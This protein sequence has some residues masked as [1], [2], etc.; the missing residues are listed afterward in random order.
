MRMID[1]LDSYY[2]SFQEQ[3]Q[4]PYTAFRSNFYDIEMEERGSQVGPRPA[5]TDFAVRLPRN[6]RP[7]M[8]SSYMRAY[9]DRVAA[10]SA[11]AHAFVRQLEAF[12]AN[13]DSKVV[14]VEA[15]S[16]MLSRTTEETYSELRWLLR[17]YQGEDPGPP[18]PAPEAASR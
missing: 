12:R 14:D 11:R 16:R 4:E 8:D 17:E 5:P 6:V 1:T 15:R 10:M 18:S 3:M 7:P 2:S 13:A 9:F